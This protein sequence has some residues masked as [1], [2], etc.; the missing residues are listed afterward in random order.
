MTSVHA[1]GVNWAVGDSS[2]RPELPPLADVLHDV[3]IFIRRYVVVSD[4]QVVTLALWIAHTH[5]IEAAHCTPYMQICSATKGSGKTLLLE[6]CEPLVAR[7]WLTGRVSAA[8]LV[9]KVHAERPTLLLD[10]SDAAFGGEKEYSEALRGLLNSGYRPSG[11]ASLCVKKGSEI[12]FQDFSTFGPKAIAGIGDLPGTIADRSV[13]ITLRRKTEGEPCAKWRH[14]TGHPAAAPLH[15]ALVRWAECGRAIRTLCEVE[16]MVPEGLNNRRA[17]CWEPLLAIAD[18]AGGEWPTRARTAAVNLEGADAA[19]DKDAVVE[20]LRDVYDVLEAWTEPVLPTKDLLD[21]LIEREERPW[22]TWRHDRPIT[23]RG[24][25]RLLG[26]IE[27]HPGQVGRVRGYRVDAFADAFAR[28]LPSQGCKRDS[29]NDDGPKTP[30]AIRADDLLITHAK[31][32][33]SP[34]LIDPIT[35]AHIEP[36]VSGDLGIRTV[37]GGPHVRERF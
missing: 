6:V 21:R 24:L 7:P 30:S 34:D 20:L 36:P 13:R 26:P 25:A 9:R 37:E 5:F 28:Y 10:E 4:D 33:K 16:P 27:I 8:V 18:L 14:R 11:K 1:F 19:Q 23:A 17:E 15:Q 2:E 31:L 29:V 22:A 32:T 3:T 35:H 12:G